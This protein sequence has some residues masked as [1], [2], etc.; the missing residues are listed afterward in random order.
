MSAKRCRSCG[1]T[2]PLSEFYVHPQMADGHLNHCKV[3]KRAYQARRV[4]E[5]SRDPEWAT[6]EAERHRNKALRQYYDSRRGDPAYLAKRREIGRRWDARNPEKDRAHT[7]VGNAVRDGRLHKP[8]RCEECGAGGMIH[9][10][11][12]D[13]SRPLEVKW[14]CPSCHMKKHR[15]TA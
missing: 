7:A 1:E 4:E 2:K 9:G 3:C 6:A 13:Y 10:H 14:L 8:D 12:E 5:K 11:H 15:K